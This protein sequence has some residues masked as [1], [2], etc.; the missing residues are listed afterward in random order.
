M[1]AIF[2]LISL[3]ISLF[4]K[5]D[6]AKEVATICANPLYNLDNEQA[7]IILKPF[8]KKSPFIKGV[9]IIDSTDDSIFLQAYWQDKKIIFDKNIPQT[10]TKLHQSIANIQYDGEVIGSAVV[11]YSKNQIL[12]FSKKELDFI[13]QQIPIR[14][15]FD[16]NWKPFEFKN[17]INEHDGLIADFLQIIKEKTKLNFIA[18]K[19]KNWKEAKEYRYWKDISF[20]LLPNKKWRYRKLSLRRCYL[21]LPLYLEIYSTRQRLC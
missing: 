17:E 7:K 1:R 4:A 12:N 8:L 9:K 15:V 11:Y 16:P 21:L 2:L 10:I 20:S 18:I 19:V 3:L 5:T 6:I 13:K 14:Y